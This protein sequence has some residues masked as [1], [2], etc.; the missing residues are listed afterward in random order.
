VTG[1]LRRVGKSYVG[2]G[3]FPLHFCETTILSE[4][5]SRKFNPRDF[6]RDEIN[7]RI[8]FRFA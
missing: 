2:E 8:P 7:I 3:R 6:I 1:L 4:S 5:F